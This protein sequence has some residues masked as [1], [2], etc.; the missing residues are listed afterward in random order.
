MQD[1]YHDIRPQQGYRPR[2]P[3]KPRIVSELS[4]LFQNLANAVHELNA[5]VKWPK[6]TNEKTNEKLENLIKAV[7]KKHDE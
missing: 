3:P 4:P 2:E 5:E 7:N 6:E 1:Y